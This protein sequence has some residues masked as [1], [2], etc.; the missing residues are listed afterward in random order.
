MFRVENMN[1][2]VSQ[3]EGYNNR[4]VFWKRNSKLDDREWLADFEEIL[5]LFR[6][7]KENV[8][9]ESLRGCRGLWWCRIRIIYSLLTQELEVGEF[10]LDL[11]PF[12]VDVLSMEM[13]TSFKDVGVMGDHSSLF[14]VAKALMK[15]QFLFGIIPNIQGKGKASQ[16]IFSSP[17]V[18]MLP[19]LIISVHHQHVISNEERNGKRRA[20]HCARNR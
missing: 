2:I 11:V 1:R 4:K 15:I 17:H 13:P 20:S 19:I 7:K 9:W 8:L 6:T 5:P 16:V 14:F 12:D 10:H 18:M 3:V